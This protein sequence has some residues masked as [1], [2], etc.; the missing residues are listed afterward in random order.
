MG[1]Y[2]N[3]TPKVTVVSK[4]WTIITLISG[5]WIGNVNAWDQ[6][7]YL[8]L[9]RN[10]VQ[11][12]N[13]TSCWICTQMPENAG[14]GFPLIGS[15]FPNDS[16]I[17]AAFSK[18]TI[19][20]YT[21]LEVKEL[22]WSLDINAP[23]NSSR[24][25]PCVQ[26]CS[27]N[28][29]EPETGGNSTD[30]RCGK[31]VFIG[32]Y[33]NC[34]SYWKY[35]GANLWNKNQTRRKNNTTP[36]G[37]PT[38]SGTGWY[39]ICGDKARKVLPL[40]WQ[41]EC[42][43]G[44]VVPHIFIVH[45][46][47]QGLIRSYIKRIRRESTNPLIQRPTAFHSFARWFF[48]WLGVSELEKALVN[49]S[50]TMEIAMNFTTDAIQAQQEEIKSISRMTLQ[51]RLALDMLLSKEG[52]VCT[53]INTSCCTYINNDKRVTL[54]LEKIWEQTRILHEITKDDLSWSFEGIWNKLTSW[55]PDLRW[56]KQ[57]FT[58]LVVFTVF[59]VYACVVFRC[60]FWCINMRKYI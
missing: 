6:N 51:N 46:L 33:P 41:G 26:R 56:I 55:L 29:T 27:L 38:P 50:A 17:H 45:N 25:V 47:T 24:G 44:P 7:M 22:S 1:S 19:S 20:E 2:A 13:L 31:T 34:T 52:G 58:M 9:L 35:G 43:V 14:R 11:N 40:G 21:Q 48:P 8:Q 59:G 42:A 18:M 37:W 53:L 5:L 36:K 28:K 39:W 15:A 10:I 16:E 12:F 49:L 4:G 3:G 54:D 60:M 30:K 32:R 23:L 57:I